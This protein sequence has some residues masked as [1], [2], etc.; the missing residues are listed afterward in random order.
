MGGKFAHPATRVAQAK[1]IHTMFQSPGYIVLSQSTL[2]DAQKRAAGVAVHARRTNAESARTVSRGASDVHLGGPN[3][4]ANVTRPTRRSP[5]GG[6]HATV[7]AVV[8][9]LQDGRVI[10]G[11]QAVP[12]PSSGK[13][14][15]EA[16]AE[17]AVPARA[18]IA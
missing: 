1:T 15:V 17:T 6:E 16:A 8:P 10:S 3:S 14:R 4:G 7:H 11:S 2:S 12:R 5:Y 18:I 9:A 13:Q